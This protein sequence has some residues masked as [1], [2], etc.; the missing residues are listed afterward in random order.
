MRVPDPHLLHV[1]TTFERIFTALRELPGVSA[2][3]AVMGLPNGPYGSDGL[4]A[5]EGM[6]EFTSSQFERLPH[7]G[8]RLTSPGYFAAMG[9][10]LHAPRLQ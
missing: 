8:F 4:Y 6:H 5:V 3:A 7:A 1:G 9:V 10:P 2:V